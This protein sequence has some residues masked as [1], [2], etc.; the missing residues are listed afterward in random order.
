MDLLDNLLREDSASP[1]TVP[2]TGR[3][4]ALEYVPTATRGD[5]NQNGVETKF[6][7]HPFL[8]TRSKLRQLGKRRRRKRRRKRKLT[9]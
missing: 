2:A 8:Q 5:I 4:N 6:R 3:A 1:A 7:H 9:R